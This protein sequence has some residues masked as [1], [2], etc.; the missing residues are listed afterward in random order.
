MWSFSLYGGMLEIV[1]NKKFL[2]YTFAAGTYPL[3]ARV[4]SQDIE[5]I[6]RHKLNFPFYW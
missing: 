5:I 4:M 3:Q 6:I 1:H 2:K